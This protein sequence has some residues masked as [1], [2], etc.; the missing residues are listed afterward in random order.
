MRNSNGTF[1]RGN[2][3][4]PAGRPRSDAAVAELAMAHGPAAIQALAEVLGTG[5]NMERVTAAR[6][7]LDRG[8][9]RPAQTVEVADVSENQ[10]AWAGID[11]PP[12]ESKDAYLLLRK[13]GLTYVKQEYGWKLVTVEEAA[14]ITSK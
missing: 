13:S 1:S 8:F 2:S 6:I 3:G 4:N 10:H 7:L 11:K 12:S 14:Q 5:S 9:G